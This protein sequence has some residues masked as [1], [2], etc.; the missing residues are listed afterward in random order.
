MGPGMKTA[1]GTGMGLSIAT[2]ALAMLILSAG[3][4]AMAIV[5]F[6]LAPGY[7][8]YAWLREQVA[9]P[10]NVHQDVGEWFAGGFALNCLIWIVL[11]Q[12]LRMMSARHLQRGARGTDD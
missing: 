2:T 9:G 12:G 8:G 11:G 1:I 6:V 10:L 5:A 4:R 3:Y 7:L